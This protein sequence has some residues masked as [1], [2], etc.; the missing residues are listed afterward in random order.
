MTMTPRFLAPLFAAAIVIAGGCNKPES[1]APVSSPPP[2][3]AMTAPQTSQPAALPPGHPNIDM[4]APTLPQSTMAQA[5]NPQWTVPEGWEQGPASSIRRGSWTV[6]GAEGQT[7]DIAITAFP[8]DV[9]G[10]LANVNRWRAQINLPPVMPDQVASLASNI[11]V[12]GTNATVVDFVADKPPA[13]KTQP[14]RMVVVTVPHA[15]NS[16]FFK[17]TGDAPLVESQKEKLLQFVK[18]VKF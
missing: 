9:G 7:A 3:P 6:K 1:S 17:M 15:G 14:Q 8:G 18:S 16:W 2:P 5:E 10:L 13:G 4:N 11:E 12:N